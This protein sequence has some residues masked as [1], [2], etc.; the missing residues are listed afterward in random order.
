MIQPEAVETETSLPL[1]KETDWDFE[2]N[3][4]IY[5]NGSP[6]I[7]TGLRAVL[8]WAWKALHVERYRYEIYTWDYGNEIESLIGKPYTDEL[9]KAEAIRY[10]KECLLINPYITDVTDI[11]VTFTEDKISIQCKIITVYGEASLNV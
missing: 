1:Y 11:S 5:K 9:K 6:S 7:V 10:V 2:R 3:I 4:P 8:V